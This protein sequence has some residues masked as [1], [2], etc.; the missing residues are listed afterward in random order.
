[1]PFATF[2]QQ[3]NKKT[4]C[5]VYESKQYVGELV[6]QSFGLKPKPVGNSSYF[7]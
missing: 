7:F 4:V 6:I 3:Y 2:L 5:N 1:M